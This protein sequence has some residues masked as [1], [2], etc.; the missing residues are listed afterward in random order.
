MPSKPISELQSKVGETVKTVNGLRVEAGKV[1]EFANAIGDENPLFR[2]EDVAKAEGYD[3]IPAPLTFTRVAYFDRYRPD[4]VDEGLGFNLG[5]DQERVLH[6]EQAYEYE[7]PA[8]VGDVLS[9]ET[10]LT[11]VYQ[12]E[13]RR[14]GEMTFA[15]YVTE[16]RDEDDDLV[17]TERVT[18]IET[19]VA[20]EEPDADRDEVDGA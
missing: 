3:A 7:R 1:E 2:D 4:D 5:F 16:F 19:G 15:V 18:R 14:G 12:R 17:L 10:T 8:V 13:G 9:G 11:D 6:G 20:D